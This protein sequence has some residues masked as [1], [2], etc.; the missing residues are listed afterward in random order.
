MDRCLN[1]VRLET[2]KTRKKKI[3]LGNFTPFSNIKG[4]FWDHFFPLL[5]P[6]DSEYLKFLDI[7]LCE[8]GAKRPLNGV[9]KWRKFLKNF[10]CRG[11]FTPFFSKKVQ[12]W[13]HF[14]PLLFP[15]DSEYLKS[16][17][18]G[19]REVGAKRPLNGVNKVWRTDKHT[20]QKQIRNGKILR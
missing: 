4:Q 20:K 3:C 5:F 18:I 17:D 8:V 11:D 1:S 16:L 13:D 6:K 10:F 15:K 9:N 14:F 2:R 7:A 19:L 12:I